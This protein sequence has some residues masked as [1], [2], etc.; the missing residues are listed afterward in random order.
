MMCAIS[1][2]RLTPALVTPAR[3][4]VDGN[5]SCA[6]P[7]R[8]E[9]IALLQQDSALKRL[10]YTVLRASNYCIYL[11]SAV[12]DAAARHALMRSPHYALGLL[13]PTD[14]D[15][16]FEGYAE[17]ESIQASL[18]ILPSAPDTFT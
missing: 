13:V 15:I 12:L 1:N 16:V 3:A 8:R 5:F 17:R 4:D 7:K 10:V 9:S 2:L 18:M 11:S 14:N 6:C